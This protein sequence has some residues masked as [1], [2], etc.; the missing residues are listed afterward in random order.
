[1]AA[2]KYEYVLN[3]L[4]EEII[5]GVYPPSSKLPSRRELC[6]RFEVSGITVARAAL[7]LKGEGL[8]TLRNGSGL[9]V[10]DELPALGE[11]DGRGN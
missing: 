8:L 11:G 7:E 2:Y 3:V 4:R 5:N 10:V 1:M 9:Y 6:D